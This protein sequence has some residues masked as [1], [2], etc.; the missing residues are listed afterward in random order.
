M[1]VADEMIDDIINRELVPVLAE[2]GAVVWVREIDTR[3]S[4]CREVH[5]RLLTGATISITL[6][7]ITHK[8]EV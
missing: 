1:D 3:S 8:L 7:D 2:H 4:D 6:E 5:V